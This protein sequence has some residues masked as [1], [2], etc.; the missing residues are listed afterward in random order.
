MP[1]LAGKSML[2]NQNK[3]FIMIKLSKT[4]GTWLKMDGLLRFINSNFAQ[5]QA[6]KRRFKSFVVQNQPFY[7]F[8]LKKLVKKFVT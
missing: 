4:G 6:K 5:K 2:P 3:I 8:F 7:A 1:N